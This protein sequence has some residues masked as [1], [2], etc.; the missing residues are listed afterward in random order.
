[1]LFYAHFAAVVGASLW[2]LIAGAVLLPAVLAI[3]VAAAAGIYVATRERITLELTDVTRYPQVLLAADLAAASLWM[4]ATA[5]SPRS[6]AF[7]VVILI[8]SLGAYSVGRRAVVL[9]AIA[10]LLG[11]IGQEWYRIAE[12]RPSSVQELVSEISIIS[13]ITLIV[14]AALRSY[15][16]VRVSGDRSLR[17]AR[18]LELVA[19]DLA[20]ATEPFDVL[21]SIPQ[22]ALSIVD[23]DY[24]AIVLRRKDDFEVAAGAGLAEKIV[25]MQ[26]SMS[27]GVFG[28][29][30]ERRSTIIHDDYA[31][32][33][34]AVASVVDLGIRMLAGIPVFVSGE[35][36]ACLTIGRVSRRP[37]DVDELAALTGLTAHAS[38]A[39]AN[40]RSLQLARRMEGLAQ[41]LV[42]Q[43]TADRVLEIAASEAAEAFSTEFA[44]IVA[45]EQAGTRMAGGVGAAGALVGRRYDR[46]GPMTKLVIERRE[47]ISIRDY[48]AEF[49][50]DPGDE[51]I[52]VDR[53]GRPGSAGLIA[54]EVGIHAIVSTPLI[55][56]DSVAAVLVVGTQD[57]SRTF[58]ELDRQGMTRLAEI[59]ARAF[60]NL[61][62][63]AR[64]RDLYLATVKALAAAVDAR[65]PYTRSHS[66]RVAA[67]AR[68]IAED[69]HLSDDEVRQVQLG[70][71]LHDLGKIG[72]PDAILNKPAPLT[73]EEWAVMRTHPALGASILEG[74]EPLAD[75]VPI[76]RDHHEF[77]DG[78][79]YPRGSGGDEV[80]LL[81]YIVA[82]ADAYEVIVTQRAYK[83]AQTLDEALDELRRC[84]GTQF[85][86]DVVDAFIR[87]IERDVSEGARLLAR[88]GAIQQEEIDDV[89]GPG[90]VV[91]QYVA[92]AQTH[93]RRL[94]VLQRLAGEIGAVLDLDDL[95]GR[96]LRIVCDAMGYEHGFLAT[97]DRD[98]EELV[99]RAAFGPSDQF[100]G[101]HIPRGAGIS[102][103]VVEHGRLQ[104]VAD[105][106]ADA[107]FWG[108]EDV[109]SSLIVPLRVE[110]EVLGVLG[111]ESPRRS[112]FTPDDEQLL[113]AVSHQ[114]SAAIR[115]ANLHHVA[116]NAAATDPLTG[117]ANRRAFFE[118]LEAALAA[119]GDDPLVTVV[120][121]DV[122]G[123]KKLN[124]RHGHRAGDEGLIRI[125][126]MLMQG[127]RGGDVVARIGGDEFAILFSGAPIFIADRIMQRIGDGL[128]TS[129]LSGGVRVP[130]L[131]WGLAQA[132]GRTTADEML[133]MADRAMYR[134]KRRDR[135]A[136]AGAE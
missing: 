4:V 90:N 121:A 41:R 113:T 75:L 133:E 99:V 49:P 62:Q 94:A 98:S 118:R 101:T 89:P 21:R 84:R 125:G 110:D 29:V 123:L 24:A 71:L 100:M 97:F 36:V 130:S 53:S 3:A 126:E 56:A 63:L 135:P 33:P 114:I 34:R 59:A 111:I 70:A 20:S 124:D 115:V 131:S 42:A 112:A 79:G 105:A 108:P 9:T 128:A 51:P 134:H 136:A 5:A 13:L 64:L 60:E 88:V 72:I 122:D 45:I 96:L 16:R 18:S 109:R 35:L 129:L 87:V 37:L 120:L 40:A 38:I 47:Q 52:H 103:W 28:Q 76:V 69:M 82:V 68:L 78:R 86:P 25:G 80:G 17:R 1:M 57:P 104:N 83:E 102:A 58:D 39:L 67:L 46:P 85:H 127:V 65:D 15:A 95:A 91:Q 119:A 48:V 2:L 50:I 54:R 31:R 11:R 74:V 61:A 22:S 27:E 106:R 23:A 81:A 55:V 44:Y 107:R 73:P 12:G 117:L 7:I 14:A 30:L 19:R 77:Y 93:G 8:G 116:R 43:P 66:A 32:H 6:V 10:Y 26:R 132:A 92:R